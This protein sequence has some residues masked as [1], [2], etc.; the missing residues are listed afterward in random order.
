MADVHQV[1]DQHQCNLIDETQ[2]WG[3][4]GSYVY[5]DKHLVRN[6]TNYYQKVFVWQSTGKG[7]AVRTTLYRIV[8]YYSLFGFPK[9]DLMIHYWT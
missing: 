8:Y 2:Q 5:P 4:W 6:K 3:Q 9:F 7:N 1:D